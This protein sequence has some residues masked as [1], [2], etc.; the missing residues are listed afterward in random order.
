MRQDSLPLIL[1]IGLRVE[2]ADTN[3]WFDLRFEI[4]L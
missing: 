4:W 3:N 2:I 1:S